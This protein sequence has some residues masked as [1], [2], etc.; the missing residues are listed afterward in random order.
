M[1]YSDGGEASHAAFDLL[2]RPGGI[3]RS[4]DPR[5]MPGPNLAAIGG[6]AQHPRKGHRP[7]RRSSR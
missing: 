4:G 7:R 1:K 3:N 2:N 6:I 5:R